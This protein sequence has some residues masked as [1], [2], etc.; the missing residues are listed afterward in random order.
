MEHNNGKLFVF[1]HGTNSYRN[2]AYI[3]RKKYSGYIKLADNVKEKTLLLLDKHAFDENPNLQADLLP[4]EWKSDLYELNP[5][6][7]I[8]IIQKKYLMKKIS[9]II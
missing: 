4:S 7:Y 2:D 8:S 9:K 3:S 5:L 1:A 6:E